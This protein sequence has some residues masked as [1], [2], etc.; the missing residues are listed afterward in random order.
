VEVEP[1]RVTAFVRDHGSGF[2]AS[3]IPDDRRGIADSI[4]GRMERY[5]GSAEI[6]SSLGG[7]TEVALRLPRRLIR[8][9]RE[10][11]AQR[12]EA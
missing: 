8:D 4:I 10:A 12:A 1:E 5:G 11:S 7:G 2:N 3:A 6:T 9:G